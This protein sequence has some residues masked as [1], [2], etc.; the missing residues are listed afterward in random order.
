MK[1]TK[2]D[3]EY[4]DKGEIK[5]IISENCYLVELE[6]NKTAVRHG[7]LLKIWPGNVG[8]TRHGV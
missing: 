8:Y 6:N 4:S 2:M 5:R 7:T 3:K 1:S